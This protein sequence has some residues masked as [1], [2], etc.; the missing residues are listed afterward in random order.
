MPAG[1]ESSNTSRY[2]S[3]HPHLPTHRHTKSMHTRTH[4]LK[5]ALSN[6][7]MF[8]CM[9]SAL[10]VLCVLYVPYVQYVLCVQFVLC[11]QCVQFVLCVLCNQ[12]LLY[13]C[14]ARTYTQQFSHRIINPDGISKSHTYVHIYT[15]TKV[16]MYVR[17]YAHVRT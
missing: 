1:V 17:V 6:Y 15:Y 12:P 5:Y 8:A 4:T 14:M 13:M 7:S 9:C 2:S 11:V 10:C 3:T 16:R